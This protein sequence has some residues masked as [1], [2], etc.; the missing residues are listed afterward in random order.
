MPHFPH[1]AWVL[2]AIVA[3]DVRLVE[4]MEAAD[5]DLDLPMPPRSDE[6]STTSLHEWADAWAG[7]LFPGKA[8]AGDVEMADLV[9]WFDRD[10][11][12][13]AGPHVPEEELTRMPAGLRRSRD[14]YVT[15]IAFAGKNRIS[16][17]FTR[18]APAAL[19]YN[20]CRGLLG[21]V[22]LEN[23]AW[24]ST[25]AALS[26]DPVWRSYMEVAMLGSTREEMEAGVEVGRDV[27]VSHQVQVLTR[28]QNVVREDA[29]LAAH[30]AADPAYGPAT[31]AAAAHARAAAAAAG[32]PL[33]AAQ[34]PRR[35]AGAPRA[36]RAPRAR[37]AGGGGP[38]AAAAAAA[39]A[40]LA[41]D[42][43][44]DLDGLE[45][46]G[47]GLEELDDAL[48]DLG[49]AAPTRRPTE[50]VLAAAAASTKRVLLASHVAA[51]QG[52]LSFFIN[53][54][55]PKVR[56]GRRALYELSRLQSRV[57]DLLEWAREVPE[58]PITPGAALWWVE[59]ALV[60]APREAA[61]GL[62]EPIIDAILSYPA[63]V[64]AAVGE[65]EM[66]AED[67][68]EVR[69]FL[70]S[71]LAGTP[72]SWGLDGLPEGMEVGDAVT[73]AL[74]GRNAAIVVFLAVACRRGRTAMRRRDWGLDQEVRDIM[75]KFTDP[76]VAVMD[77]WAA[78][79]LLGGVGDP[80]FSGA[81]ARAALMEALAEPHRAFF[82]HAAEAALKRGAQRARA[83][84]A[85]R[86]YDAATAAGAAAMDELQ[87]EAAARAAYDKV[88]GGAVGAEAD[89]FGGVDPD[90]APN[91]PWARSEFVR[92]YAGVT[93]AQVAARLEA[94]PMEAPGWVFLDEPWA[95][96]PVAAAEAAVAA[97][98]AA[99]AADPVAH[100]RRLV[101]DDARRAARAAATEAGHQ[102]LAAREAAMADTLVEA[103]AAAAAAA[104]AAGGGEAGAAASAAV[105]DTDAVAAAV[106]AA[107]AA[108]HPLPPPSAFPYGPDSDEEAGPRTDWQY[109][110]VEHA[111]AVEHRGA[112]LATAEGAL[113][114]AL[115]AADRAGAED[116]ARA[117]VTILDTADMSAAQ[118]QAVAAALGPAWGA[119]RLAAGDASELAFLAVAGVV[120]GEAG[121]PGNASAGEVSGED[122]PMEAGSDG[123]LAAVR[124][125]EG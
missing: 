74:G 41:A 80:A 19:T 39:V 70:E 22:V 29:Y 6:A 116:A 77:A 111:A 64:A 114:M 85:C 84:E 28:Y 40:A 25:I 108:A 54:L 105:L 34:P 33:P 23:R 30:R 53:G 48:A 113:A 107:A 83:E 43:D 89:A 57:D 86:R 18:V 88:W 2:F 91:A 3:G 51:A 115:A 97:R 110:A 32:M 26:V 96:A 102:A 120:P 92:L 47:H 38:A 99:E 46:L 65:P 118:V 125:M 45:D 31:V 87:D 90:P 67:D 8:A 27:A 13:A 94:H 35:A 49:G 98:A 58:V 101:E 60:D 112:T 100:G 95:A 73:A 59:R 72:K 106:A 55:H 81:A 42:P 104:L 9:A 10:L 117:A 69:A 20:V 56:H 62:A 121:P 15:Q 1:R 75:A 93:D 36:P 82:M 124:E 14:A 71:L 52:E 109:D 78:K 37:A 103:A 5:V 4:A 61:T 21:R 24:A 123:E 44:A 17:S 63:A 76:A 68:A 12:A 16:A 50:A 11:F 79:L 122:W 7:D 119:A 66:P